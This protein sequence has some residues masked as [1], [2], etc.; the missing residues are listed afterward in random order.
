MKQISPEKWL[1]GD[2]WTVCTLSRTADD[3]T[4]EY[5]IHF[6]EELDDLGEVREAAFRDPVAGQVILW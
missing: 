4:R 1:S 6:S 2:S 3:L 5:G